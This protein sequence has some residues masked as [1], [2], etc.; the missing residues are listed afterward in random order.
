MRPYFAYGSNIVG[1]AMK[2]RCPMA[3]F[4][5]MARL[6][7]YR[8]GIVRSGY[9]SVVP[10][11]NAV[12]HGVLWL[13][14]AADERRLD[15]YEEIA[16]GLYQRACLS[17]EPIAHHSNARR[18]GALVY[19]AKDAGLGRPRPDYIEPILAAAQSYGFPP[20]AC[21]EIARW[22]SARSAFIVPG[23]GK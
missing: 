6:R 7:H 5:G 19:L 12:V 11:R 20:S 14:T 10:E 9:A 18:V 22:A 16:T 1:D 23:A 21:A 17:V 4:V 2:R 13:L 3:K 15:M 8:F